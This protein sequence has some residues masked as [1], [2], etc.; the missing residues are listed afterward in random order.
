MS[1]ALTVRFDTELPA[2]SDWELSFVAA[3]AVPAATHEYEAL[4]RK[5][6]GLLLSD[7]DFRQTLAKK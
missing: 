4:Y 6:V 5:L 7:P 3:V 2:K 1:D